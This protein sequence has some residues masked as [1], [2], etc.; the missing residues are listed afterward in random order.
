MTEFVYV[1]LAHD[2]WEQTTRL[3]HAVLRSS[4]NARV[5]IA[6]DGRS[7][8]EPPVSHEPRVEILV[9]GRASDWG[10]W[11]L[12]EA[13]LDALRLAR[14]R[15]DPDMVVLISGS[16]YPVRRLG[17]WETEA[18][19]GGAWHGE[20]HPLVYRPRWGRRLGVGDDRLTRYAYHWVQAPW[21]RWASS[22]APRW[23]WRAHEA[24]ALRLEPLF[25][26]RVVARGRGLHYGLRRALDR[27]DAAH[28]CYIGSQ[29]FAASRHALA[30]LLDEDFGPRGRLRRIYRH[31]VIPD[32][33]AIVTALAWRSPRSTLPPVTHVR[34][35]A[36]ADQP[37]VWTI[38]DLPELIESGSPFCRK[39]D[40]VLSASLLDEL[41]RR[42][43]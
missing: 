22:A 19:R 7:A 11:E 23:W 33:S 12:V 17:E 13:T 26:V 4:P 37:V 3:A 43:A 18:L 27:F 20:A 16:D 40:P 9:H 24:A 31:T 6:L 29:W 39:V 2:R 30:A 1:V 10:S 15:Y 25:G 38:D 28:P 36:A 34:W 32:E 42:I 41:D 14:A 21:S 5:L 35:D 8:G